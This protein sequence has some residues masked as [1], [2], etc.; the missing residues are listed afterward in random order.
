VEIKDQYA[1]V[2]ML[3]A[4]HYSR[5]HR[6]PVNTQLVRQMAE[7]ILDKRSHIIQNEWDD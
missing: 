6:Q 2:Y 5:N 4:L 7:F 1:S 3:A